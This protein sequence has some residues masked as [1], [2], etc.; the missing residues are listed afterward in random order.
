MISKGFHDKI[1]S[2]FDEPYLSEERSQ[3]SEI[4]S[5]AD[6]LSELDEFDLRLESVENVLVQNRRASQKIAADHAQRIEESRIDF[7]SAN[8]HEVKVLV[9][10]GVEGRIFFVCYKDQQ[11]RFCLVDRTPNW[12]LSSENTP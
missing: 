5:E 1:M 11:P 6:N 8:L 3:N 7:T 4:E 12:Y 2:Q 10:E 9:C